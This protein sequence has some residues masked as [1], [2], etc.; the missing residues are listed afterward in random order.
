MKKRDV[1]IWTFMILCSL[2]AYIFLVQV[3]S[4]EQL[5]SNSIEELELIEE[6]ETKTSP[7]VDVFK[8]VVT[9]FTKLL[10]AS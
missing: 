6:E 4:P 1:F 10:P 3:Q 7:D 9:V 5:M 2:S 8:H